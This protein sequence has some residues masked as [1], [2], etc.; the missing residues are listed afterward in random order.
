MWTSEYPTQLR[1]II[2]IL[3]LSIYQAGKKQKVEQKP[4]DRMDNI[5]AYAEIIKDNIDYNTLTAGCGAGDKEYVDEIVK[6]LTE[7]VSIERD[8]V[9]IVSFSKLFGGVFV[10]LFGGEIRF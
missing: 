5:K 1:L 2:K 4:T 9:C 6:L 7:A 8:T 10:S 3:I